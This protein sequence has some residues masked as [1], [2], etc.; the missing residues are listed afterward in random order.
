MAYFEVNKKPILTFPSVSGA[1]C[2]FNSQYAGLPLKAHEVAVDYTG[3]AISGID[4][5][6]TGKNLWGGA[7]LVNGVKTSIPS[8]T[9]GTDY[10]GFASNATAS[11][12]FTEGMKFKENTQYT[13]LFTLQNPSVSRSNMR[14]AY[15]D[16][17][18]SNVM[19][20]SDNT[21]RTMVVVTDANKTVIGLEKRNAGGETRLFYNE[22]ALL[23]GVKTFDN[24]VPYVGHSYKAVFDT[25]I[26][27]GSYDCLTGIVTS[28]KDSGGGD[29][30]P[31][32]QQT[33]T[34]N[35]LTLLGENNV[36]ADTGDTTLQYIKL[37]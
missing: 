9:E 24:F 17:T 4:V 26:Y 13:F 36:W 33:A 14:I 31:T 8:A 23:E 5:R 2:T 29:V 3:S 1:V 35:C 30:S 20:V 12:Y 6:I 11:G 22:C 18:F 16:G 19:N 21:K 32:Y 34:A 10:I 37:G 7:D 28:D 15:T 25:P 27:G